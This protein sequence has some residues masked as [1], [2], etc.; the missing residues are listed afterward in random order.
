MG[1]KTHGRDMRS[2]RCACIIWNKS[3]RRWESPGVLTTACSWSTPPLVDQDGADWP[4]AQIDLL[5][6][7]A[8]HV[9]SVCERK[10]S[11]SLFYVA[12]D[13]SGKIRERNST[14]LHH[15]RISDAIQNVL[16]TTY[17]LRDNAYSGLLSM[18]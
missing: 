17:G 10:F 14:F 15:T 1:R 7:R 3:G 5:L 2:N 12:R 11:Q 6:V 18:R 16:V 9:I 13:Y 8:D 4:G